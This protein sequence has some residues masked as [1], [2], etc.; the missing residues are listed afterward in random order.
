MTQ[1]PLNYHEDIDKDEPF[2]FDFEDKKP[3]QLE[4]PPP[5]L[6]YAIRSASYLL[7]SNPSQ[8]EI[9][10]YFNSLSGRNPLDDDGFPQKKEFYG[11]TYEDLH[12][13][14]Q[15]QNIEQENREESNQYLSTQPYQPFEATTVYNPSY[16]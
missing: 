6:K 5:N 11:K 4:N 16:L 2:H 12:E 7:E 10:Q 3:V 1:V 15:R 14:K 9:D 8:E 13:E